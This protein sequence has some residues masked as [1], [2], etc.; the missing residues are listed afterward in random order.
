VRR[1]RRE[2]DDEPRETGMVSPPNDLIPRAALEQCLRELPNCVVLRNEEDLFGHLQRG[3]DVDLLVDDLEVAERTLIRHLGP[4]LRIIKYSYATGYSFGWGHIDVLRTIE[5]QGACYLGTEAI[6][7]ARRLSARGRPVPR[8]AHEALIS[9]FTSLLWG[10]FFKERYASVIRDAA[11]VDGVALRQALMKVAGKNWGVR[12]WRAAA[13]GHPEISATWA[14]AL[15][16]ALWWRACFRS[17]VRTIQGYFAFVIGELRRRFDPPVPW[18]G[19]VGSDANAK[20]VV[21]NEIVVRFEACP[22]AQVKAFDW[23]PRRIAAATGTEPITYSRLKVVL[24][25]AHWLR[26]YWTRLAHR[27]AQGDILAFD[28]TACFR[29]QILS[30]SWIQNLTCSAPGTKQSRVQSSPAR[31]T[32]IE[33]GYV[34]YRMVMC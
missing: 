5:W 28:G 9:W 18:I 24:L 8:I 2:L 20:S 6:L 10:G 27:R 22:Y 3:G 19:I 16:R 29:H 34:R 23:R 12:L 17:P 11:A 1:L 25:A 7:E 13:A 14:Q 30:S 15:R 21:A 4:P 31:G 26:R 33:H 32:R